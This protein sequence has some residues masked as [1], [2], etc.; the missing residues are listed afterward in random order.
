MKNIGLLNYGKICID[1]DKIIHVVGEKGM[2]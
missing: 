1:Y 2:K